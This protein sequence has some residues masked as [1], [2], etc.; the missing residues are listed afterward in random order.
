[1]IMKNL[2]YHERL[3]STNRLAKELVGQGITT[4]A[5]IQAGRQ[6]AGRGQ[7]ERS[8]SSPSGGLYFSLILRPPLS[9]Q[10]IS[11]V[12][13]A[14]GLGCR[15]AIVEQ[16]SC[17]TLIKWPNDLYCSGKKIA[18]ILSEHCPGGEGEDESPAV[19]VGVGI[20]VNNR[21][22]DFPVELRRHLST[23]HDCC[24]RAFDTSALLKSC[25]AGISHRVTQLVN[26]RDTFFEDWRQVDY[27][28]GRT[29][30]HSLRET[31]LGIG[32]GKGID[33]QGRY[34]L[35]EGGQIRQVL[36]GQLRPV[37]SSVEMEQEII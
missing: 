16:C 8:F 19:V 26:S 9:V 32:I 6:N 34:L 18:G 27:L 35:D 11:L 17:P 15:D 24:G 23:L 7:Y 37:H 3:D 31:E 20:N 21:S 13:L 4:G 36:G 29:I 5:V 25:V 12:T 2:I 28:F 14:A 10:E 33:E 1:M 30:R 22:A